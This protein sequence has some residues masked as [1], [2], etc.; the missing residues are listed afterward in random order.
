MK[1]SPKPFAD[2]REFSASQLTKINI[3]HDVA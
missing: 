2:Y 1:P 3:C